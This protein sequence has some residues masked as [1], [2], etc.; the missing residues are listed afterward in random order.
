MF[1]SSCPMTLLWT[2]CAVPSHWWLV[3]RKFSRLEPFLNIVDV[4]YEDAVRLV[5]ANVTITEDDDP[6]IQSFVLS[7]H[8]EF[9]LV[10]L[11]QIL[12]LLDEG[13]HCYLTTATSLFTTIYTPT[14]EPKSKSIQPSPTLAANQRPLPFWNRILDSFLSGSKETLSLVSV[15]MAMCSPSKACFFNSFLMIGDWLF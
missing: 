13:D 10:L 7:T 8:I 3:R 12:Q 6:I 11:S 5:Y 14:V 1:K 4:V 9:N 2:M 15:I